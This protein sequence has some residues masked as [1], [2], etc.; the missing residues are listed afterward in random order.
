MKKQVFKYNRHIFELNVIKA[1]KKQQL[2]QLK[3]YEVINFCYKPRAKIIWD[4]AV[5]S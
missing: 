4:T 2:I 5:V 3:K 1:K